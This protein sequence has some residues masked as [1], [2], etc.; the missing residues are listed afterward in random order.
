MPPG[1]TG[2]KI[3]RQQDDV[4]QQNQ[5]PESNPNSV[6]EEKSFDRVMPKEDE[7]DN[8]QVH[9]IAM[10]I[11]QDEGKPR[12]AGVVALSLRHGAT[13]RIEKKCAVISLAIVVAGRA[14]AQRAA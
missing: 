6:G 3:Q 11:L 10:D 4:E 7:E 1:M 12:L 9:E 14:E 2:E 8:R 5:G 13:W